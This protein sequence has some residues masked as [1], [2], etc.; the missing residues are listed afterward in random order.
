MVYKWKVLTILMFMIPEETR[1]LNPQEIQDKC[2]GNNIN[3]VIT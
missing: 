3:K 2:G 1:I